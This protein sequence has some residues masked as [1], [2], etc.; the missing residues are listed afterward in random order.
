MAIPVSGSYIIAE[1]ATSRAEMAFCLSMRKTNLS[2]GTLGTK[3]NIIIAGNTF[4]LSAGAT[5]GSWISASKNTSHPVR[6]TLFRLGWD[7]VLGEGAIAVYLRSATVGSELGSVAW[8]NASQFSN[9]VLSYYRHKKWGQVKIKLTRSEAASDT[10]QVSTIAIEGRAIVPNSEVLIYPTVQHSIGKDFLGIMA[11][12]MRVGTDNK[13]RKWDELYAQSYVY[14]RNY[15]NDQ[16][17][18]YAGLKLDSGRVEYLPIFSGK[19]DQLGLD[20]VTKMANFSV[21]GNLL[22]NL[23]NVVVGGENIITGLPQPYGAGRRYRDLLVET[24]SVLRIW[25]YYSKQTP[26]AIN[27]VYTRNVENNLWRVFTVASYTAS[28]PNKTITFTADANIQGDVAMDVTINSKQHPV[29]ILKDILDN[30][31]SIKYNSTQLTKIEAGYP[32]FVAGVR[33]ESM[34]GFEAVTRLARVL[35]MAVYE[36]ADKLNFVSLQAMLPSTHTISQ[37]DYKEMQVTRTKL[38]IANKYSIPY[39]DYWDD[40]TKIVAG[41]DSNSIASFGVR[42]LSIIYGGEYSYTYTDPISCNDSG[43]ITNLITKLKLRL[44]SQKEHV[45]LDD[46]FTKTLRMELGD[47]AVIN[48][49]FFGYNNKLIAIYERGLDLKTRIADLGAMGYD[50][51]NQFIFAPTADSQLATEWVATPI[52]SAQVANVSYFF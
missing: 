52:P 7:Q 24:N 19:T 18:L 10:P 30:E 41:S 27:N 34:S 15:L 33:F 20:S 6:D 48:N 44:P 47:K 23:N 12:Q 43:V 5:R 13:D 8:A 31:V 1:A 35:D 39:G 17:D 3:N 50:L 14:G 29:I 45:F 42:D 46:V 37:S 28:T 9:S 21:R 36:S 11:S 22:D 49:A 40:K 16:M 4:S 32:D 38:K 51:Y 2:G 25:T 26:T